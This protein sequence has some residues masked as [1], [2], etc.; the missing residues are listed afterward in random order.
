MCG[1]GTR[2]RARRATACALTSEEAHPPSVSHI[3]SRHVCLK[4]RSRGGSGAQAPIRTEQ[5][6][7]EPAL[8]SL[9]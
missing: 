8:L 1:Y 5:A 4:Q 7:S 3:P 2:R 9:R 6:V